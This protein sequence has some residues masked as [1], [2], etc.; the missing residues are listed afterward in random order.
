[1][2]ARLDPELDKLF[3]DEPDLLEL[4]QLLRS[5]PHPAAGIEPSAHFRMSLRRRLMREAWDRA[6]RPVLPWYRRLLEPSTLTWAGAAVGALLVVFAGFTFATATRP[7]P[8]P[9]TVTSPLN[10]SQTVSVVR[11]IE[12]TFNQPM[13]PGT[14]EQSVRIEPAI[15]A[16]YSWQDNN[17][18]LVITPLHDLAA[19]TRYDVTVAPSAKTQSG[20]TVAK[21]HVVTFVTVPPAPAPTPTPTS[22]PSSTPSPVL[23]GARPVAPVGTPA[24]HWSADGR[25]FIVGPAGQLQA[26]PLHGGPAVAV[27]P[28]GVTMVEVG[29]DG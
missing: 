4:A 14:T 13:D 21:P 27:A 12:L 19:N 3:G 24:A 28:D 2:S 23:E 29:P 22:S 5:T 16:R 9:V 1:M 26:W 10:R 11:P 18:R 25:L 6:Q 20:Q 17:Q 15:L 8:A 7:P